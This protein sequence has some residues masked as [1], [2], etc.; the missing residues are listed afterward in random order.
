MQNII[1]HKTRRKAVK[2]RL[3]ISCINI[4]TRIQHRVNAARF[5]HSRDLPSPKRTALARL[6]RIKRSKSTPAN[7]NRQHQHF[8]P[9]STS[10]SCRKFTPNNVRPAKRHK[11]AAASQ[12][13]IGR[14]CAPV[15]RPP[16]AAQQLPQ[17]P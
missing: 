12:N 8:G 15:R 16:P 13:A 9:I 14:R 11:M 17:Q 4:H 6:G 7:R 5:N 2:R 3:C 1:Q 10:P